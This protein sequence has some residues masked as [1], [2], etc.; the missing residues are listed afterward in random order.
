MIVRLQDKEDHEEVNLML[1]HPPS[2][3]AV[4]EAGFCD[5]DLIL[6]C[7]YG[8]VYEANRSDVVR[9]FRLS[10]D[11]LS[12]IDSDSLPDDDLVGGHSIYLL[13]CFSC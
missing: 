3:K 8:H 7:S 2:W 9:H 4:N 5:S 13:L 6:C 11:T 10:C 12:S 1:I